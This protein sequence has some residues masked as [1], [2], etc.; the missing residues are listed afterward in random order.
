[1]LTRLSKPSKMYNELYKAM[2]VKFLDARSRG[3]CVDFNWLWSKARVIYREQQKS[4]DAVVKKL[5]RQ[6]Y[7]RK[8][9][10]IVSGP[11]KKEE[12]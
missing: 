2:N 11:A 1:M 12:T 3:R 8:A 9:F 6:F 4:N 5:Y 7:Q 10:K